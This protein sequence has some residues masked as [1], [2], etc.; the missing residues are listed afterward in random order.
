MATSS[1]LKSL[2]LGSALA[3]GGF[4]GT[5]RPPL[6]PCIQQLTLVYTTASFRDLNDRF[7]VD[8]LTVVLNQL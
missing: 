4:F 5:V 7:N 3:V 2:T 6:V 8:G 1:V